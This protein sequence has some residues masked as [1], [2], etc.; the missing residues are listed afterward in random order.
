MPAMS[1]TPDQEGGEGEPVLCSVE[2]LLNC[3]FSAWYPRFASCTPRSAIIPLS[4]AVVSYLTDTSSGTITLPEGFCQS[5]HRASTGEDSWSDCDSWDDGPAGVEDESDSEEAAPQHSFPDLLEK[6]NL[7][8]VDLGGSAFPKLNWSSPRDAAWMN[9]G[10]LKCFSPG[11]IMALLKGSTFA[12]HDLEGAFAACRDAQ[13]RIKPDEITLVLRKWCN[14]QPGMLF[15]CFVKCGRLQGICQRDCCS[16]YAYLREPE[17]AKRI[18]E[19]AAVFLRE[20][21]APHFPDPSFV[22][23]IYVDRRSR[24]WLIDFNPYCSVTDSLLFSW[25]ELGS[26]GVRTPVATELEGVQETLIL[27]E[28][29][30]ALPY[31]FPFRVVGSD[32]HT[33]A[34]PMSAYRGPV[35]AEALAGSD[36]DSFIRMCAQQ[37]KELDKDPE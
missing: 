20:Q 25:S 16:F 5:C 27:T 14:L 23:D 7:A 28:D 2:H 13:G 4:E 30:A 37:D 17:F 19:L 6:I 29:K 24:V 33:M 31:S 15:R 3:Q 26:A 22:L 8:L 18:G 35:D 36:F 12:S 32:V 34:D 10:S 1:A 11:D 9:G 21:A